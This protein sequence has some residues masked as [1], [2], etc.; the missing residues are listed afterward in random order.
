RLAISVDDYGKIADTFAHAVDA[1]PAPVVEPLLERIGRL[2]ESGRFEQAAEARSRLAAF[3]RG[4]KRTQRV[5]SLVRIGELVAARPAAGGGWELAVVRHG[6]LAAAG[7]SPPR[8]D[9]M[10]IVDSLLREA[11]TVIPDARTQ[12]AA[13]LGETELIADWLE[14][15]GI[16]LVRSD[17]GWWLPA[18]GA[19]RYQSLLRRLNAA[20]DARR[21]EFSTPLLSFSRIRDNW[22][23]PGVAFTRK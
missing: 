8:T 16:R 23:A 3:L 15:D 10:P 18:A 1:D 19:G 9:P 12:A 5:R 7:V 13:R 17:S 21:V 22:L 4:V 11:S 6:L 2:A 20:D 14:S